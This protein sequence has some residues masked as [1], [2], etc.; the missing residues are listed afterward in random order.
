MDTPHLFLI[1]FIFWGGNI[2]KVSGISVVIQ[3]RTIMLTLKSLYRKLIV[4]A[5]YDVLKDCYISSTLDSR[6]KEK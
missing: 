5:R 6:L 4:N 2:A 1:P 3:L